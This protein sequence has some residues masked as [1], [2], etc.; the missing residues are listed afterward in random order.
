MKESVQIVDKASFF[1]SSQEKTN[2]FQKYDEFLAW[3]EEKNNNYFVVEQIAFSELDQW[4]FTSGNES[5]VHK[6]GKFFRIEGIKV[7]TNFGEITEWEQPIIN[8]PE[9]GI[10]GVLTKVINGVR[11]FLMQAKME[12]GNVNILQLSPTVQ[13]TKSNFSRVHKG[14]LPNY[15]EY[16]VD[17]SKSKTLI[18]QLQTE[19]G[20][21]FLRKRN[22]NIVIEVTEEIEVLED[23]CWLTLFEIKKLLKIDNFVNMDARSVISTIPLVDDIVVDALQHKQLA[24][25]DAMQINERVY[26][27]IDLDLIISC[28]SQ[29]TNLSSK[30]QIISW[31]TGMKVKYELTTNQIPLLNIKNW[32]ISDTNINYNDRFFSVIAVKVIAGTREV[33]S[34]TQPLIKDHNIGLIGFII[35][36]MDGVFHFLVQA[37]VEPGN[38]DVIELSPSVSCS[39]YEF[40]LQNTDKQPPFFSYFAENSS[41]SSS[42]VLFDAIQSEEG[43]RFY[44]MQNRNKIIILDETEELTIPENYCWMTLNQMM[45]FM[46]YSMF[47]IE[48]RSLISSID[49]N[50]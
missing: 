48:A 20:G 6:S 42:Y 26:N 31:Y 25:V 19:Q 33:T 45:D 15:L 43:G 18:D 50:S 38:L 23:F 22:R 34:W 3:F 27:G 28:C 35:K 8:Q 41:S 13:A 36:K 37:K 5:L 39:N 49:F 21:R 47:N 1:F 40:L 17:S 44:Q 14:K 12:P 46:R 29:I 2:Q 24:N 7:Q 11:Y 16:F 32:S 30:D 4:S 10:L 9:I